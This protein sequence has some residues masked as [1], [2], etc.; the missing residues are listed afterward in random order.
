M[1]AELFAHLEH[2]MNGFKA[3]DVEVDWHG[4]QYEVVVTYAGK[5]KCTSKWNKEIR[6]LA[7]HAH[8]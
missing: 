1:K 5:W 2:N 3:L 7:P 6:S 8:R 4:G